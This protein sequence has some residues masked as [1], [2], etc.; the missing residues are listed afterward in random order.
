MMRTP[1]DA[2][3]DL[4]NKWRR[5][6]ADDDVDAP[7]LLSDLLAEAIEN[8]RAE[9]LAAL[10][11]R[12]DREPMPSAWLSTLADLGISMDHIMR[13]RAEILD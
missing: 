9:A 5:A 8:A 10:S 3:D 2:G 11:L 1:R 7:S 13:K 6:L 12:L 4:I